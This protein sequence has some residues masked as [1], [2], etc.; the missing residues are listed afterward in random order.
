MWGSVII[1]QPHAKGRFTMF[2]LKKGADKALFSLF[3]ER[4]N[5][6]SAYH[7]GLLQFQ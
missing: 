1:D 4:I 7:T 5:N 2:I 3:Q 6:I